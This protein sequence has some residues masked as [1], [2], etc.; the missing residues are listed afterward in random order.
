MIF[1]AAGLIGGIIGELIGIW[2]VN[3]DNKI[4]IS[5]GY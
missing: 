4:N 3:E 5:N 2:L 1:I